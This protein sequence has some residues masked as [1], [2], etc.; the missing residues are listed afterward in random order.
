MKLKSLYLMQAFMFSALLVGCGD[1]GSSSSDDNNGGSNNEGVATFAGS[2]KDYL[3]QTGQMVIS[4][5]N[6][7]DFNNIEPIRRVLEEERYETGDLK[8]IEDV[9]KSLRQLVGENYAQY[10][11]TVLRAASFDG[12]YYVQNNRWYYQEA[13]GSCQFVF[14][15]ANGQQVVANVRTSGAT[16]TVYLFDTDERETFHDS[17]SGYS[18][19]M[20]YK[21]E[22]LVAIPEHI[23]VTVTQGGTT[24]LEN[25]T[26]INL[27]NVVEGQKYDLSRNCLDLNTKTTINGKYVVDVNQVKYTGGSGAN[28]SFTISSG[29]TMIVKGTAS[30]TGYATNEELK[31]LHNIDATLD[32][33]GRVQIKATC[34]DGKALADYVDEV[35]RYSSNESEYKKRIDQINRLYTANVYYEGNSTL[36]ATVSLEAFEDQRLSY[37]GYDPQTGPIYSKVAYW[38][39]KPIIKFTSDQ[40]SYALEDYFSESRFKSVIDDFKSLVESVARNFTDERISW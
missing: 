33:M 13:S 5:F 19:R 10:Y 14:P 15:D 30:A 32:I 23:E 38:D 26:N 22:I 12:K 2:D 40:S 3:E 20:Y 6:K 29:G 24:I 16:K 17:Y 27:S 7:N 35:R 21:N 9:Y 11:R 36:R 28:V 1:S 8:R 31:S 37:S 18:Y 4:K 25:V 34:D 39:N